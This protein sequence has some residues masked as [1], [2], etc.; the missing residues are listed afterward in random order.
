MMR[1]I[2][3]RHCYLIFNLFKEKVP[4]WLM[5]LFS[6]PSKLYIGLECLQF[7]CVAAEDNPTFYVATVLYEINW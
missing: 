4:M 3:R 2:L 1:A 6:P 7:A 5:L